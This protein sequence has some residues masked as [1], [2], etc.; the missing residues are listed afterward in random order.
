MNY[1]LYEHKYGIEVYHI[2]QKLKENKII[3]QIL[4]I[5]NTG[6]NVHGRKKKTFG[7]N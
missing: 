4:C 3:K 1:R 5:Q 7:I 2:M 6:F